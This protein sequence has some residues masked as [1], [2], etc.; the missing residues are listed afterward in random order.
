MLFDLHVFFKLSFN[1]YLLTERLFVQEH[2]KSD[3]R[4]K[5]FLATPMVV[6]PKIFFVVCAFVT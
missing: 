1:V 4:F 2:L 3:L 6:V 5:T